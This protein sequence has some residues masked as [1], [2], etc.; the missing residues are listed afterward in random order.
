MGRDLMR[1]VEALIKCKSKVLQ[2][3]LLIWLSSLPK[4]LSKLSINKG[5]IKIINAKTD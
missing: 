4:A 3:R 5:I 2:F 1:H